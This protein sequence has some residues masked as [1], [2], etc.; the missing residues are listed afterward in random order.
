MQGPE[1]DVDVV[2][3]EPMQDRHGEAPEQREQNTSTQ[4]AAPSSRPESQDHRSAT[5][6]ALLEKKKQAVKKDAATPAETTTTDQTD[7]GAKNPGRHP[8]GQKTGSVKPSADSQ[9]DAPGPV[10]QQADPDR[11]A[12]RI[13]PAA[14]LPEGMRIVAVIKLSA[15]SLRPGRDAI[16]PTLPV[17]AG[18]PDTSLDLAE[19][20]LAE[21]Q[22]RVPEM[23]R[24][25]N[26]Q[27]GFVF[28]HVRD[29]ETQPLVWRE[30]PEGHGVHCTIQEKRAE[31]GWMLPR[32]TEGRTLHLDYANGTE[33]ARI[34]FAPG[35]QATVAVRDGVRAAFWLGAL[36]TQAERSES[37]RPP[38]YFWRVV[39]GPLAAS[40]WTSE[41]R[42]LDGAGCR[43]EVVLN[44]A[45]PDGTCIALIDQ[46]TG[47]QLTTWL[48]PAP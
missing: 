24:R 41:S 34:E 47:W 9:S 45:R 23:L 38:Y 43:L 17:P 2:E 20:M 22:A 18:E 1:A 11:T 16:V 28:R 13:R 33:A 6:R 15:W 36:Y 46:E 35:G 37:G 39:R 3:R 31:T 27:S 10:G 12:V 14:P 29:S 19:R 40:A 5:Q 7:A 44:G 21:L 4:K 32:R 25:P 30:T 42:W 26:L 8:S 48:E